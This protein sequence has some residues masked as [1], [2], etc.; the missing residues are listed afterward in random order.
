MAN[1]GRILQAGWHLLNLINEILDL[2]KIESGKFSLSPEPV[3][4]SEVFVECMGMIEVQAQKRSIQLE[5]PV[6]ERSCFVNADS[7]RLKQ[8]MLN[9][10]SNAVKYN[11]ERGSV[12]VSYATVAT[13][14]IRISIKDSGAGLPP[15]KLDQ[16]FQPFNRLGQESSSE[17]GTGIGLVVAKQLIEMMGGEIGVESAVGTG[18]TFWFELM[19]ET[20]PQDIGNPDES[21]SPKPRSAEES[22][23]IGTL[24]Y[25]EDNPANLSLVEQLVARRP[26]LRLLTAVTG[27]LGIELARSSHPDIILMD[28]N[29]PDTN[30]IDVL[31]IL[32]E[33]ATTSHIPIIA[34]SANAM[35]H[36]IAKGMK[37]GFFRYL[38]KPIKIAEFNATLDSTLDFVRALDVR[39]RHSGA[40]TA[41]TG[42]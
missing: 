15:D 24:L 25:V 29:L 13:G 32:H 37:A 5:F 1:I 30:G 28:I 41:G 40:G 22:P 20:E 17:E 8:V 12:Q 23:R 42:T 27:K 39:T 10:L 16:L 6:F 11:R 18:S 36:D 34:I 2:A 38:T 35:P 26:E 33:G 3:S 9:L 21:S 14:R 7:T 4:L 31:R 19:P